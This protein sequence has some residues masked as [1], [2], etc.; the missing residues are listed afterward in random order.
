MQNPINGEPR[1]NTLTERHM[2]RLRR[3]LTAALSAPSKPGNP[4]RR[5]R[6]VLPMLCAPG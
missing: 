2:Q 6:N 5:R 1:I 3:G 4:C